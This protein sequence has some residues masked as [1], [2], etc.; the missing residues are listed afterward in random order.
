MT[1]EGLHDEVNIHTILVIMAS[2]SGHIFV[3]LRMTK[4]KAMKTV[5]ATFVVEVAD[6]YEC[7]QVLDQISSVQ[8]RLAW[9]KNTLTIGIKTVKGQRD[10][11]VVET[12]QTSLSQG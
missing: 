11:Q 4:G 5:T 6:A 12:P 9:T 1:K 2:S 8:D 10:E 7:Q 3:Y